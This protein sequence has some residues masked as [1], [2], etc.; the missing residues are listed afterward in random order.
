MRFWF[1]FCG[2]EINRKENINHKTL[3]AAEWFLGGGGKCYL[4]SF[5]I[6]PIPCEYFHC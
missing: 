5:K 1:V 4:F 3:P 6:L 2:G